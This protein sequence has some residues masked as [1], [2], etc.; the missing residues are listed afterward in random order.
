M[1]EKTKVIT[2]TVRLSYAHIWEPY[3]KKDDGKKYSAML[4]IPKDDTETLLNIKEAVEAAYIEGSERLKNK[5]AKVAPSLG[6]IKTPLHDGDEEHPGEELYAGMMYLNAGNRYPVKVWN[7]EGEQIEDHD[8]IY[9]G[10]YV[11]A[12]I[13][14][15]AYNTEGGK[16]IAASLRQIMKVSDGEKLGGDGSVTNDFA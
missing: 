12:S 1:S 2:G 6:A 10:C 11:K 8:E 7:S 13:E 15:Y 3:G 5:G 14:F 16:G 4:L 9:S